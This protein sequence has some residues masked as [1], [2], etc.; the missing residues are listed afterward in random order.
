MLDLVLIKYLYKL[1]KRIF[2]DRGDPYIFGL[3]L[4]IELHVEFVDFSIIFNNIPEH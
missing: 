2:S 1:Q 3:R 4:T